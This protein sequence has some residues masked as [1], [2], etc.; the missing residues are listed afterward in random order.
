VSVSF[1]YYDLIETFPKAG[2]AVCNLL[3]RNVSRLLSSVLYEYVVDRDMQATFRASRGLC[4]EH[5]W[6][7][8]AMGNA[9]GI[10]TLHEAVLDEVLTTIK[11][12][13]P[14]GS[15]RGRLRSGDNPF[16]AV[17]NALEPTKPCLV[18]TM[19]NT[20]EAEYVSVLGEHIGD[21]RMNAAYRGSHG[22]CL[23]HF[24]QTLRATRNANNARSIVAIQTVIWE[25]LQADLNEFMRKQNVEYGDETISADEGASWQRVVARLAGE[26]GVF[27]ARRG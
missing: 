10:A 8:G 2:C 19:M 23:E 18:C 27:S 22:L 14:G 13:T 20:R 16:S 21:E 3:I 1:G 25:R 4:S 24:R 7:M 15:G 12:N 17:A 11:R 26:K 9:L 5:A 6:Q